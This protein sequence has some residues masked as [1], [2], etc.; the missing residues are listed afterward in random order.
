[1]KTQNMTS[2]CFKMGA[3]LAGR[4]LVTSI[5][6]STFRKGSKDITTKQ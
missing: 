5:F 6:Q 3:E 4:H 1:M 2:G